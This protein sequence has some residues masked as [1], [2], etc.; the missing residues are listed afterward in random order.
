MS[1]GCLRI[2]LHIQD[3][4]AGW[5]GGLNYL[6]AVIELLDCQPEA[7]RPDIL[8]FNDLPDSGLQ[9]A[10]NRPAVACVLGADGAVLR[11]READMEARLAALEPSQRRRSLAEQADA[12]YPIVPG[13]PYPINP[14]HWLWVPDFQHRHLP[15]FFTPEEWA[16]REARVRELLARPCPLI[17]SSRSALADLKSFFPDHAARPHVWHFRSLARPQGND[18]LREVRARYGLPDRFLFIPNQFWAHKDHGTAF[19]ALARLREQGEVIQL[20]C[21]GSKED[22]RRPDYYDTLFAMATR[23]GLTGIRHLGSI[24]HADVLACLQMATCVIQ[25]SRF[26]GWSTLVEDALA[27]G[28]PLAASQLPVHVEQ[29][30]K[31]GMFFAPGDAD[32]LAA[33]LSARLPGLPDSTPPAAVQA[34]AQHYDEVRRAAGAALLALIGDESRRSE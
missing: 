22:H 7:T 13:D 33:L 10:L 2:L 17:L 12:L 34:A 4:S 24:P 27:L 20:I 6:R 5:A 19:R 30:G 1:G 21:T 26:E 18:R 14:K 23:L 3:R 28:V 15:E 29:M 25:P 31:D 9:E 16:Q 11:V 8:V 32:G